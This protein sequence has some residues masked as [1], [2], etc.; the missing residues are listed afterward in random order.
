MNYLPVFLLL[1]SSSIPSLY[2]TKCSKILPTIIRQKERAN[3]K[4]CKSIFNLNSHQLE[5]ALLAGADAHILI[6]AGNKD[7]LLFLCQK[8]YTTTKEALHVFA[9][10]KLLLQFGA[11]VNNTHIAA[12]FKHPTINNQPN[13][14]LIKLFFYYGNI[15]IELLLENCNNSQSNVR[16]VLKLIRTIHREIQLE[17]IGRSCKTT[18]FAQLLTN[19]LI[20][21]SEKQP[22][23]VLP[24]SE[25][26][27]GFLKC[28]QDKNPKELEVEID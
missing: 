13:Q 26:L 11:Q 15:D 8:K 9:C 22:Y 5:R 3:H 4:F 25:E 20:Q 1:I 10:I 23:I 27:F 12:I 2:A 17:K 28:D 16:L 6:P 18:F 24:Y 7:P 14:D 21:L 19:P